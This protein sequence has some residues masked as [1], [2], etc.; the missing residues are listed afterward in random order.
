MCVNVHSC[1]QLFV[2]LWIIASRA[3]QPME[4]SRHKDCTGLSF[5]GDLPHPE[6][7]TQSLVSPAW[8]GRFFPTEPPGKP[9]CVGIADFLVAQRAVENLPAH[10]GDTGSIWARQNP[11]RRQWQSTTVFLLGN[12]H[13]QRSLVGYSPWGHKRVRHDLATKQAMIKY[14][15]KN[16]L[17]HFAEQQRL[18]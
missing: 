3:P 1:V 17:I 2:T 15:Q 18:T 5:P 16:Q 9:I 8:A 12:S 6:T 4:F 10:A 14:K 7:E 11:W 13:G